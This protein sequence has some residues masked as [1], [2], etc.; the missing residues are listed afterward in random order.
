MKSSR[1]RS[2]TRIR[3]Y[4]LFVVAGLCTLPGAA[5]AQA[6]GEW[7]G[8]EHIFTSTC[9]Y[10]HTTGVGPVLTGRKLEREYVFSRVREGFGPMPAFKPSE[11]DDAEL[12]ALWQWLHDSAAEQP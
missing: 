3:R 5:S 7:R 2:R 9:F 8:P 11:L 6:R 10:C 4:V 12:E 1:R